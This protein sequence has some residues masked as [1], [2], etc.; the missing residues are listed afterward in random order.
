VVQGVCIFVGSEAWTSAYSPAG[1]KGA[2]LGARWGF[3]L[4]RSIAIRGA[5]G[6]FLS[7]HC[8]AKTQ[9]V[10]DPHGHMILG[11]GL[12]GHF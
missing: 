3:F 6:D 8:V 10:R 9:L 1:G 4:V 12:C 7:R 5:V 11:H 2:M